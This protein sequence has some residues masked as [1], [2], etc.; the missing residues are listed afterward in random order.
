MSAYC[1]P[2]QYCD[3][4]GL[5]EATQ[6]LQDELSDLEPHVLNAVARNDELLLSH[7][8]AQQIKIGNQ[9]LARLNM[10]L[11][12]SAKLIDGYIRSKV[13]LPMT[14]EQIAETSLMTCNA[15][16]ARCAL[17]DDTDNSTEL[18]E[19]KCSTWREFLRDVNSG[20]VKLLP[21]EQNQSA[22]VDTG[23]VRHGIGKTTTNWDGYGYP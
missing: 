5:G 14:P 2:R 19:K 15:H 21:D 8:S 23:E 7:L 10:A 12:Q 3:Q 16:L 13:T 22:A 9:A 20:K 4:F 6:L 1:N 18:S 17:M 11:D